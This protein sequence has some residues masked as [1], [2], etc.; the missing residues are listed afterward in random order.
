[1]RNVATSR[2]TT[3]SRGFSETRAQAQ[4]VKVLLSTIEARPVRLPLAERVADAIAATTESAPR[5]ARRIVDL[6]AAMAALTHS[7]RT[8]F[9]D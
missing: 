7:I 5:A 2:P 6:N 1:M 3:R 8:T 4:H 9:L